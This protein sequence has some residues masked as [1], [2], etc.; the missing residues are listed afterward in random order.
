MKLC[1]KISISYYFI[2]CNIL[3]SEFEY[4]DNLYYEYIILFLNSVTSL[5]IYRYVSIN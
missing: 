1:R 4:G 3:V 5:K 2:K